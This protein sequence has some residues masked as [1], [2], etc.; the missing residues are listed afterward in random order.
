[1]KSVAE[2]DKKAERKAPSLLD[3]QPR[4]CVRPAPGTSPRERG[5]LSSR[6]RSPTERSACRRQSRAPRR[7]WASR[8]RPA[9]PRN[10][11]SR[12]GR[13]VSPPSRATPAFASSPRVR[14]AA[15]RRPSSAPRSRRARASTPSSLSRACSGSPGLVAVSSDARRAPP[16]AKRRE[17]AT[18]AKTEIFLLLAHIRFS[19]GGERDRGRAAPT[20]DRARSLRRALASDRDPGRDACARGIARRV[21][22]RPPPRCPPPLLLISEERRVIPRA[23]NPGV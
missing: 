14:R 8:R 16:P 17:G 6:V 10:R 3:Q 5:A 18:P 13:I 1:M 22:K 20:R 15:S 11:P 19:P 2:L 23:D 4:R 7:R 21:A 9:P 12:P